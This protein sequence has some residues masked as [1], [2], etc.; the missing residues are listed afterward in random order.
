MDPEFVLSPAHIQ[1]LSSLPHLQD[2][3]FGG[4]ERE[5]DIDQSSTESNP[6]KDQFPSL[7]RLECYG[8]LSDQDLI[9]LLPL[10]HLE[11]LIVG[12]E[13]DPRGIEIISSGFTHLIQLN[14]TGNESNTLYYFIS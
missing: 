4:I 14:I 6:W 1:Q 10:S 2:L 8:S 9:D 11:E 5:D 3:S 7:K 12:E 13:L